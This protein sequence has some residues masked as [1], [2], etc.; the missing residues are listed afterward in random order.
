[1]RQMEGVIGLRG[2]LGQ[3]FFDIL[4][5]TMTSLQSQKIGTL[6]FLKGRGSVDG[7]L[8]FVDVREG[9]GDGGWGVVS[10]IT[11]MKRRI[12]QLFFRGLWFWKRLENEEALKAVYF[13]LHYH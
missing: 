12:Q 11:S 10:K 8:P 4:V 5:D 13:L 2:A 3:L 1:M 6:F 9:V 7:A